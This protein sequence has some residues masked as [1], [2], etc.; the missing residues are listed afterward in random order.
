MSLRR[1]LKCLRRRLATL[2]FLVF[3]FIAFL[4][5]PRNRR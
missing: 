5:T 4:W 2:S 1:M 3:F